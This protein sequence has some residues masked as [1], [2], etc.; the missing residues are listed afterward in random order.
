MCSKI[1]IPIYNAE[2]AND[3]HY[4]ADKV[5]E[6]CKNCNEDFDL[7]TLLEEISNLDKNKTIAMFCT[8][9]NPESTKLTW[10]FGLLPNFVDEDD[11]LLY[12]FL[13]P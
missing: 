6:G 5:H 3:V 1:R 11:L 12:C 4:T 7:D 8:P 10:V 2:T 13:K 9:G